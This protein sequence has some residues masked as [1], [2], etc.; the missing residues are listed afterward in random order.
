MLYKEYAKVLTGPG[1]YQRTYI[2][3]KNAT[4]L[5]ENTVGPMLVNLM[6]SNNFSRLKG[7]WEWGIFFSFAHFI[8]NIFTENL[9]GSQQI[10]WVNLWISKYIFNNLNSLF[11]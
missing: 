1:D 4:V 6:W 2:G 11:T 7:L 10:Y 3:K 8:S 9:V 5:R